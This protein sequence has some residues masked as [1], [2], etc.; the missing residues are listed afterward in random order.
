MPICAKPSCKNPT[1]SNRK[2]CPRCLRYKRESS[3]QRRASLKAE[4]EAKGLCSSGNCVR[5][6]ED[7]Y[8]RCRKCREY[9]REYKQKNRK[10]KEALRCSRTDCVNPPTPGAKSCQRCRQREFEASRRRY[11]QDPGKYKARLQ[12]GRDRR[13][14]LKLEVL[15]AYGGLRCACPGCTTPEGIHE[16]LSIDHVDGNGADHRRELFGD[17]KKGGNLYDWLKK[18]DFPPGFRVL[19]M[20]CNFALGHFGY[21]P[22]GELTQISTTGGPLIPKLG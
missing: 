19:C 8:K 16:F 15:E 12:R 3:R 10:A 1:T 5:P 6:A 13:R 11:M 7:G 2:Q 4:R 17:P 22:H 18:N 9:Q 14:R 21:C 20:N